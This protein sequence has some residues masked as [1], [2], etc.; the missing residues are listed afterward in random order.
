MRDAVEGRPGY[1]PRDMCKL[2]VYGNLNCIRSS[3]RLAKECCRNVEMKWLLNDLRPDFR[4][5]SDF[6]KDNAEGLV[7]LF[8]EFKRFIHGKA[9]PELY[10]VDGSKFKASNSRSRVFTACE[11]DGRI[12]HLTVKLEDYLNLLDQNDQSENNEPSEVSD[13]KSMTK[14]ELQ[15]NIEKTKEK[16][17]R[18][19][20][21]LDT[22]SKSGQT[23]LSLTDSD[24]RLMRT[25]NG[26]CIGYNLQTAA[27]SEHYI[28]DFLVSTSS[29]DHGH[30]MPALTEIR[31]GH[32]EGIINA[33]A[34]KG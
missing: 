22:L 1:D 8:K 21:Y 9:N 11:L 15:A 19:Q 20:K 5:I 6:R 16:L 34:D 3:R 12:A 2:Y 26:Y 28:A 10:S 14:E 27:D 30:L 18:Y 24:A 29:T 25:G 4:T 31:K 7:N 33:T 23:Q 17:K 13:F 32:E